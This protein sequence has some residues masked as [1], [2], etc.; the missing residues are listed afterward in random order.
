VRIR[1]ARS[2]RKRSRG[3][4]VIERL[5]GKG[6]VRMSTDEILSLTRGGR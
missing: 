4:S 1:R 5:R 2:R 3:R 6:N